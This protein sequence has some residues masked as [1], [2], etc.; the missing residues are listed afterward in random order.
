MYLKRLR[1]KNIKCY[2][3]FTID[4]VS[5]TG[6]IR[7]WTSILGNNGVGK[8][9]ILQCIALALASGTS[10][11][12]LVP[13]PER[14]VRSNHSKGMFEATIVF[15]K[16][17]LPEKKSPKEITLRYDVL[18]S[19][20]RKT[21]DM[22]YSV[23]RI[24]EP[25]N[26]IAYTYF[27]RNL[28]HSP[29]FVAGYGVYRGQSLTNTYTKNDRR[30]NPRSERI[31]S[32]FKN[33]SLMQD[34]EGWIQ[35][36]DYRKLKSENKKDNDFFEKAIQIIEKVLPGIKYSDINLEGELFVKTKSND[37]IPL[38]ELSDAYLTLFS[39]TGDLIMRLFQ[40]FPKLKDPTKAKGVILVDEIGL[41]LHP[42]VQRKIV[43]QLRE[44]FPHVQF[45]IT[46]HSPFIAQA[47]EKGEV[48][49]LED[50]EGHTV[51]KPFEG[52]LKGW[53][54]D[55]ILTT[56]FGLKT[57]RDIGIEKKLIEYDYLLQK[58]HEESFLKT[59]KQK[60]LK[61]KKEL[62]KEELPEDLPDINEQKKEL[63]ELI[64]RLK[65]TRKEK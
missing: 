51:L 15:D 25:I 45:I 26:H 41:H 56:I 44:I 3:D 20:Q 60:M 2:K 12:E 50:R 53:R 19:K 14:W 30:G 29:L 36:L 5:E 61:L 37:K 18:G 38:R 8:T 33:T 57:T 52:T 47:S 54:V 7:H 43:E 58:S 1:L 11:H 23:P 6:K 63:S 28:K 34:I 24:V 35:T 10:L 59:D 40:T 22:E 21:N 13:Y 4:F 32:L 42:L 65:E 17:E 46:S 64:K 16:S 62:D 49:V 27:T 55:Q 31:L 48:F 9:I 39:W